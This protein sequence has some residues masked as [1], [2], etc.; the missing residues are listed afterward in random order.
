MEVK[1]SQWQPRASIEVLRARA[2]LLV[3]I[4]QFF[5]Q[6]QV[7]EVETPVLSRA[8][9]T[10]PNIESFRTEFFP[11]GCA[12]IAG[13]GQTYYLATSPEFHMKRL[14]AAGSGAIYQISRVFRNEEQGRYHNPEFTLLEWYRPGFD[15]HT[16]MLEVAELIKQVVRSSLLI[17]KVEYYSY[18]QVFQRTLAIDPLQC[19]NQDLIQCAKT[20]AIEVHGLTESDRDAWLDVLMSHCVQKQLGFQSG[21]PCL[22][23]VYDYPASQAAL[24]QVRDTQPAVAERFELFIAGQELANGYHELQAADEQYRR[25]QHDISIRNQR[26]QRQLAFDQHLIDALQSGLPDCSGVALGLDRL[27]QSALGTQSLQDCL[28]FP[29][30]IA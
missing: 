5:A 4:R 12:Q 15:L 17:E 22:T 1:E 11:S 21:H 25:F 20:N 30:S 29:F 6:R 28:A 23:F 10:D 26:Q 18:Q 16:L 8:G 7:L 27:L 13:Q 19:S 2:Q 9:T 14:L 24:A 3:E